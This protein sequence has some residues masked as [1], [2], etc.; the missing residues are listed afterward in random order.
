MTEKL[1]DLNAYQ[2]EFEGMV[3]SCEKNDDNTYNVVLDKTL[4]FPE[5]GG[6]SPDRGKMNDIEVVDVQISKSGIITHKLSGA[7]EEGT[8][9]KGIIDWEH[10]F[11]NMQQHSG[12]HIFSGLVNST[13]GYNNVGFHLSDQIVTMDFSGPLTM[14]QALEIEE[15]A[16]KVITSNVNIK[17]GYPSKEEIANLE[18]RSKIEI[19][20]P[21]R[22]VEVEGVDICACCAPHVR[23]TGEIGILKIMNM[24]NYKGGVRIS[25][26]CGKRALMAFREKNF[27]VQDLMTEL[28][29]AENELI[30]QV[31]KI[32]SQ[33]QTYKQELA[34]LKKAVVLKE[35]EAIPDSEKSVVLFL[36]GLDTNTMRPLVNTL[37]S[38]HEGVCG[39]FNGNDADGYNFI[40][41]SS[42]LDMRNTAALLR[43]NLQAKCGGS[44]EMI[45]GS[46]NAAEMDI[47]KLVKGEE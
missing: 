24:Q 10:R 30:T 29:T 19:D 4:F 45:Q 44:K 34:G 3:I 39:I 43:E 36:E 16:N 23:R 15:R 35:I 18:Y 27:V 11:S 9:V 2:T 22:I 12:E 26:L 5:E 6:Q 31:K 28:C 13:Y 20:G 38:K 1:Y 8:T 47:M 46:V 41:S 32:K 33:S 42:S 21:I 37:T 7:L 40:L 25:I 14:E 17:T